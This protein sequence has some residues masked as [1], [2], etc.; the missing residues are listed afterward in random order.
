MQ[1]SP[2][3]HWIGSWAGLDIVAKR[4]IPPT[5]KLSFAIQPVLSCC[6][7]CSTTYYIFIHGCCILLLFSLLLLCGVLLAVVSYTVFSVINLVKSFLIQ[8]VNLL[9][10]LCYKLSNSLEH[11]FK[12]SN[13]ASSITFSASAFRRSLWS[14]IRMSCGTHVSLSSSACD[15]LLAPKP[16][17]RYSSDLLLEVFTKSCHPV[18]VFSH[19]DP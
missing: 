14:K 11:D 2:G 8:N 17:D 10:W 12:P 4:K 7:I 18:A 1:K 3:T 15:L 19:I 9:S 16:L 13:Q 6:L 5:R